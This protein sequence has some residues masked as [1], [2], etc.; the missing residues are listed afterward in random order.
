MDKISIIY[1]EGVLVKSLTGKSKPSGIWDYKLNWPLWNALRAYSPARVAIVSNETWVGTGWTIGRN[2]EIRLEFFAAAL[3]EFLKL[4]HRCSHRWSTRGDWKIYI[5]P[6]SETVLTGLK[7]ELEYIGRPEDFDWFREQGVTKCIDYQ[8]FIQTYGTTGKKFK[9]IQLGVL[10]Y[11]SF[12]SISEITK[13]LQIRTD[14]D[15][16]S[17]AMLYA[18][19][20]NPILQ[21]GELISRISEARKKEGD[22]VEKGCIGYSPSEQLELYSALQTAQYKRYILHLLSSYKEPQNIYPQDGEG[23]V[24]CDLCGKEIYEHH[25]W[26]TQIVPSVPLEK[27]RREWLAY[28]SSKSSTSLCLDCIAQLRFLTEFLKVAE[29]E[30]ITPFWAKNTLGKL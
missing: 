6:D 20:S 11:L 28:F 19:F 24:C 18:R 26:W 25:S 15:D 4:P 12:S 21:D 22:I 9:D 14:L 29:P 8:Q 23:K 5:H 2:Y 7:G 16:H 3:T 1:T 13:D 27:E 17:K 30:L 10:T